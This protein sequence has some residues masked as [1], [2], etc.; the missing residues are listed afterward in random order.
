MK[1]LISH[2]NTE[3]A[4]I[5]HQDP[6]IYIESLDQINISHPKAQLILPFDQ[7][8]ALDAP[9]Q[10]QLASQPI[11][12][13][14]L[15]NTADIQL[16]D[17]FLDELELVCLNFPKFTDGRAYSQAVELR[18]HLKWRGEIR[19]FGDVLRDQLDHM[20][21]CGFNSFA[22]REDKN[23]EEALKGLSS[24]SINYS[25]SVLEPL[26]LFRRRPLYK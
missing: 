18:S 24:I 12:A 21:R 26:P 8:V 13:F 23:V 3:Q 16:L 20:H 19:A 1:N 15:C 17:P 4:F 9:Q 2:V 14:W 11:K 25:N 5:D 6:W 7:F 10:K 22:I